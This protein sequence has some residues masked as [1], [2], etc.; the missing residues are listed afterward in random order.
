MSPDSTHSM[1]AVASTKLRVRFTLANGE[2]AHTIVEFA[3]DAYVTS[4]EVAAPDTNDAWQTFLALPFTLDKDMYVRTRPDET[5]LHPEYPAYR[6]LFVSNDHDLERALMGAANDGWALR[7][8][9]E[10][11]DT[12]MMV[13]M[14]ILG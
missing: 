11:P 4:I 14:E 12:Y 10:R 13:I 7:M 1:G 3:P 2:D 8:I 6:V 5:S 9:I